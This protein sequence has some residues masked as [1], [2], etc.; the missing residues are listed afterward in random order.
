MN[1][2]KE[3]PCS[4]FLIANNVTYVNNVKFLIGVM[5]LICTTD[6]CNLCMW[7]PISPKRE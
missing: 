7:E 2:C 1:Y 5:D 4:M 6:L 3:F